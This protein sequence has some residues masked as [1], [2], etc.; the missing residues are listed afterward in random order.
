MKR[1]CRRMLWFIRSFLK[2]TGELRGELRGDAAGEAPGE[3][4]AVGSMA[5]LRD[6]RQS[7]GGGGEATLP[8]GA[9]QEASGRPSPGP[10]SPGKLSIPLP[11]APGK[12]NNCL[13]PA[14][15]TWSGSPPGCASPV[16]AR[17]PEHVA[18]RWP[19]ATGHI[20]VP[21]AAAAPHKG[22]TPLP[23]YTAK[24]HVDPRAATTYGVATP[25]CH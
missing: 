23:G 12:L 25:Q 16:C 7:G 4:C 1:R 10:G 21:K 3:C 20:A 8:A 24:C 17:L 11:P 22:R 18:P 2:R 6:P 5:Q 19:H 14:A 9:E 13:A 15:G